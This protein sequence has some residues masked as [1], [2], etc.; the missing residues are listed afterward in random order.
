MRTV[1]VAASTHRREEYAVDFEGH[2]AVQLIDEA[3]RMR[4]EMIWRLATGRTV[5]VTEFGIFDP[6]DRRRGYGTRLLK[7]GLDDIRQFFSEKDL[8]LRRVYLFCDAIN[9][10]G[11]SFWESRG[12]R[13]ASVLPG[14]YHYCDVALYIRNVETAP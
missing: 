6:A 9:E 5:E 14:F 11:R 4:G 13:L 8:R 1:V 2:R 12:F 3:G 7:A 10:P